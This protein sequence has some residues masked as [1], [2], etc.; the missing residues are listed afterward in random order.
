VNN[1]KQIVKSLTAFLM[2]VALL[3]PS[4]VE[5]VHFSD[6]HKHMVCTDSSEHL[7]QAEADCTAFHFQINSFQYDFAGYEEIKNPS[8]AP[9][10]IKDFSSLVFSRFI[11]TN[12]QL[13]AP[14]VLA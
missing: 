5:L 7:H 14:P 6:G 4:V 11:R 2:L 3:F 9:T 10:K 1:R 13:R 12:A 8:Y